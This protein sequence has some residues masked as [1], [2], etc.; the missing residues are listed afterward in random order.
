MMI[1]DFYHK[2][3]FMESVDAKS[4][5]HAIEKRHKR[6][7]QSYHFKLFDGMKSMFHVEVYQTNGYNNIYTVMVSEG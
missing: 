4:L 6:G 5:K 1:F 7:M 3:I 2:G